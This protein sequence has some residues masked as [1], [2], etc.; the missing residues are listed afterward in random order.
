MPLHALPWL[1]YIGVAMYLTFELYTYAYRLAPAS[2]LAPTSYFSVLFTGLLG[3][4]IWGHTPDWI[5]MAGM[6]MVVAAGLAILI[7][8]PSASD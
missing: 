5:A 1:A 4:W 6:A 3:W 8:R 2:T 7:R